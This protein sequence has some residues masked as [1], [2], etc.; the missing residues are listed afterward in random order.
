MTF[1]LDLIDKSMPL[2]KGIWEFSA[3]GRLY[4]GALR[5]DLDMRRRIMAALESGRINLETT[6]AKATLEQT[7]GA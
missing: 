6:M 3:D 5:A 1:V 4:S 2:M 7:V